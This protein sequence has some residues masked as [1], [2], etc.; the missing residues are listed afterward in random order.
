MSDI[1][2]IDSE[3]IIT[4]HETAKLLQANPTSVNKWAADGLI[5]MHRTPGGHRRFKLGAVLAFA[6]A[7]KM[8]IA[9]SRLMALTGPV[10][11]NI[12]DAGREALAQSEASNG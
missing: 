1:R 7:H 4:S 12:T 9:P 2:R 8:P 6:D 11:Y 5:A 3:M 10:T